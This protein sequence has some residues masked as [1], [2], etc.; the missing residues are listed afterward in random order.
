MKNR[1]IE[2]KYIIRRIAI[3]AIIF[4]LVFTGIYF[5][6]AS[7]WKTLENDTGQGQEQGVIG[8]DLDDNTQ[9][10][11]TEIDKEEVVEPEPVIPEDTHITLSAV[12]DIM[13]HPRNING[14]YDSTTGTY[15]YKPY[16]DA[17]KPY[18]EKADLAVG[19]FE[20]TTCGDDIYAYQGYP[21]FNAPDEV[22]DA[23]KDTGF[24][25]LSTVNNHSLDTRKVGVIR[26]IEKM[27]ER[28][29]AH[30]G[31]Y[32]EK[33][34]TRV[35]MQ[36]V[37]GI[38]IAFLAYTEMLNGLDSVLTLEELDTMINKLDETKIIEDIAY[39]NENEAD[40][41]VMMVHW[42]Y[43][44]VHTPNAYQTSWAEFMIEQGVDIILGGHPHVMQST[45]NNLDIENSQHVAAENPY[46]IES[47]DPYYIVYSMGNFI[48]NQRIEEV[49][50]ELPA[51]TEDGI[52]ITF[53]I[54]K[55][56]ATG[57][58]TVE[59]VNYTPT[60]V[61]REYNYD[62]AKFAYKVV[63]VTEYMESDVYDDYSKSRMVR[64]YNDTLS[65]LDENYLGTE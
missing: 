22:L 52:I 34:E 11:N 15:D 63:P 31:T 16:F 62:L 36:D 21:L 57:E 33:P 26:T 14:G 65:I 61:Y 38:K 2:K 50:A 54:K 39:A 12:G 51:Q 3:F 48:S 46:Y 35:L 20:G 7:G 30:V 53:D 17:I 23:L 64:S 5:A 47:E 37:K 1:K 59:G 25:V 13:F 41:I 10:D 4:L 9:T 44:Y 45:V 29:I 58:V 24:D 18:I 42:G 56:G 8:T 55:D 43:E 32:V 27:D 28:G 40:L 60:W 49:E 6:L 19:N